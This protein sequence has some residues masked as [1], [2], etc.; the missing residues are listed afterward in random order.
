M[1]AHDAALQAIR[2]ALDGNPHCVPGLLFRNR[3]VA[4]AHGVMSHE[5]DQE[6]LALLD[7][8]INYAFWYGH[9]VRGTPAPEAAGRDPIWVA[10][11]VS[12]HWF[13]DAPTVDLLFQRY[14]YAMRDRCDYTPAWAQ[15]PEDV[16]AVRA[17]FAEA[18]AALA[19]MIRRFDQDLRDS[20]LIVEGLEKWDGK[21]G[22][23][24][25][26]DSIIEPPGHLDLRSFDVYGLDLKKDYNGMFLPAPLFEWHKCVMK[27][28]V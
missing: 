10:L 22:S 20:R 16:F 14:A 5:G 27:G 23:E 18:C 6:L 25:I 13:V 9:V 21:F 11:I 26:I 4:T 28:E 1:T 7:G 17:T 8:G 24:Q 12:S 3:V 19:E 2:D 15:D